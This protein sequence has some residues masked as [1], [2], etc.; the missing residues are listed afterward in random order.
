M[1]NPKSINRTPRQAR[2]RTQ[3]MHKSSKAKIPTAMSRGHKEV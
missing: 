1:R 2:G 3:R